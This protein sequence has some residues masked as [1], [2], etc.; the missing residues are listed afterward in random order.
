[1]SKAGDAQKLKHIQSQIDK[2]KADIEEFQKQISV[3]KKN[4]NRSEQHLG[5]MFH[6]LNKL[7]NSGIQ[8]TEHA[9]LRYLERKEG[10]DVRAIEETLRLCAE[11]YKEFESCTIP[12]GDGHKAIMK[13]HVIIT[14]T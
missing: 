4:L 12:L 13:K 1:M 11:K 2:D 9:I 3:L 14:V 8:V 7:K 6:Q 10:I 5:M